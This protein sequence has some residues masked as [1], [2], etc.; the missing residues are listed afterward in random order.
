[1]NSKTMFYIL[2]RILL[3]VLT[4]RVVITV[5]FFVMRA[6]PGGPFLGEKAVSEAAIAALEAKYGMD[7]PLFVNSI[8]YLS[9]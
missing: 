4:V 7:Q 8:C 3:A 2:K 6:V 1:M 9:T 5:T